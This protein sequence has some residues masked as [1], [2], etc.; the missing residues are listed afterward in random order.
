MR[1]AALFVLL[2][3]LVLLPIVGTVAVPTA[4]APPPESLCSVCGP[5]F[6]ESAADHDVTATVEHATLEIKLG[7]NGNSHW[8]VTNRLGSNSEFEQLRANGTLSRI[9]NDSITDPF[10]ERPDPERVSNLTTE[11]DGNTVIVE[12]DVAN[13]AKTERGILFVEYLRESG[14]RGLFVPVNELTVTGPDGYG[15]TSAPPYATE[16][17]N[18]LE[19]TADAQSEPRVSMARSHVAFGQSEDAFVSL[20]TQFVVLTR[21][22][23]AMATNLALLLP[24]L[25][26]FVGGVAAFGRFGSSVA[27]PKRTRVLAGSALALATLGLCYAAFSGAIMVVGIPVGLAAGCT[28]L[29][30]AGGLSL[31][32]MRRER[33]IPWWLAFAPTLCVSLFLGVTILSGER[34]LA[35]ASTNVV[36]TLALSLLF[37]LGYAV[38]RGDRRAVALASALLVGSGFA[39][40]GSLGGFT[41]TPTM[42][43]LTVVFLVV[44]ALGGLLLGFPLYILGELTAR[45][46]ERR[47]SQ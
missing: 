8:I 7:E 15:V 44:F 6:A 29:A 28:A 38:A 9:V 30:V 17:A 16:K 27:R 21:A 31:W 40:V 13:V 41:Q 25:V 10:R 47:P 37:P 23:P 20:T 26:L 24:A 3:S 22:A 1:R 2:A 39:F 46:G 35:F 45:V 43:I 12:F 34:G 11:L 33:A 19:W 32:T 42:P 14:R 18:R 4:A 5:T 36:G